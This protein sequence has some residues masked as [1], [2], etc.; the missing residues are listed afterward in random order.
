MN[1]TQE[2]KSTVTILVCGGGATNIVL[3][4]AELLEKNT[5]PQRAEVKAYYI[6]SSRASTRSTKHVPKPES[7][8]ALRNVDGSGGVRAE[9]FDLIREEI[10][11]ILD[12]CRPGDYTIVVSTTS[13]GSGS[14]FAPLITRELMNRD[15]VVVPIIIGDLRAG[16]EAENTCKTLKSYF[17]ASQTLKRSL[18]GVYVENGREGSMSDVDNL[19]RNYISSLTVLFSG[20]NHALDSRDVYNLF[21]FEKVSDRSPDFAGLIITTDRSSKE[22]EKGAIGCIA[23]GTDPDGDRPSVELDY[24]KHG[25]VPEDAI[26][27]QFLRFYVEDSMMHQALEEAEEKYAALKAVLDSRPMHRRK[28]AMDDADADGMF[29]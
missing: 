25:G 3:P 17:G 21:R 22:V 26:D 20:N 29:V 13:G 4:C 19:V 23:I 6:D 12:Q 18:V 16:K 9:H 8:Y 10:P 14:V 7:I 28:I 2:K 15:K 24:F 11:L 27:H 5:D 1:T